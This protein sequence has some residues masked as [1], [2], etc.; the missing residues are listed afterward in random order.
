[1]IRG[2]IAAATEIRPAS[3]APCLINDVSRGAALVWSSSR[4][5]W[6]ARTQLSSKTPH[7]TSSDPL[8]R[9]PISIVELTELGKLVLPRLE[10]IRSEEHT[11][12]LQSLRHLVCRLLLEKKKQYNITKVDQERLVLTRGKQ[13]SVAKVELRYSFSYG[14]R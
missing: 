4:R 8:L 10:E 11:S 14:T 9:S 12:E 3:G 1:M 7:G 13:T 6:P 5:S 2:S